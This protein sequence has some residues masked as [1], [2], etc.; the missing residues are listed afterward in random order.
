VVAVPVLAAMLPL[1][2]AAPPASALP[3]FPPGETTTPQVDGSVPA[4]DVTLIGASPEEAGAP[5]ANE[6][7]GVGKLDE[8]PV[9]VRYYQSGAGGGQWTLGPALP[10]GFTP[11]EGPLAATITAK[12]FGAIVGRAKGVV[13]VRKP[14][15]SF[16]ATTQIPVETEAE[17]KSRAEGESAPKEGSPSE[18]E[19]STAGQS[20]TQGQS[21]A[22]KEPAAGGDPA[23]EGGEGGEGGK[24]PEASAA[25]LKVGEELW[26]TG[27]APLV[28]ALEE[29][30]GE[31]GAL[32]AP[33]IGAE[34]GV[35]KQVLH[36]DAHEWASEPID[37]PERSA[38]EF[39]VLA[40]AASSPTNAW[41]LAQPAKSAYPGGAV[42]LFR[43]IEEAGKWS[44][45]PVNLSGGS[46]DGEVHPLLVPVQ[47]GEP[48]PLTVPGTGEPPT[49]KAQLL[50]VTSEGVWIDGRRTDVKETEAG[51]T[52]LYFRPSGARAAGTVVASWCQPPP[53]GRPAC[54]HSLPE[55]LPSALPTGYSRSFAWSGGGPF[56]ERVIT[57]GRE[58][59]SLRLEGESFARVQALGAGK[60][61]EE[62]PGSQLGAAF[63]TP[64]EGW[65]GQALLPVHLT[66]QPVA[67]RLTPW[68]VTVRT[69]LLAVAPE[70][71]A[72]VGSI[73]SEALAVGYE[74]AV[75]RYK[76][77]QGWLPETLFGP[78]EHKETPQLRAIAWPRPTRAYAVGD[79]GQMWL[80]RGET[81]LWE[82]DPA[83]PINFRGNLVGVAFDPNNPARGYAVG[84]TEVGLGGVLLRYGKTWTEET[85]LPPQV[86]GAAF[87]SI[88]FAGS[89]AIVA[90][91]KQAE[92]GKP[93]FAGGL[94]VNDGSGWSVD[95]EAASAFGSNVPLTVA[96]LPDGG[97]AALTDSRALYER[98]GPGSSWQPAPVPP[99]GDGSSLSLFR[100]NGALRAIIA[101]GGVGN[102]ST[103]SR[104]PPGSPPPLYNPI[105]SF[106][107]G[108]E[109]A[110]I[111]RQDASGWSDES[112]ELDPVAEPEGGYR[113]GWDM[114]YR[115]DPIN[116]V[117]VDST[118]SQGW[119][120]GGY[121]EG[122]RG[123]KLLDT[124]D[125]ERYPADGNAP[126]GIEQA[127]VPLASADV[128]VAIGGHAE[129]ANPC[130][131]RS[132]AGVGP[133]VWLTAAVALARK[134]GVPFVYTGPSMSKAEIE[135]RERT[136]PLSFSQEF[137][138]TASILSQGSSPAYVVPTAQDRDARPESAGDES[139]FRAIFS[140]QLGGESGDCAVEVNCSY[141]TLPEASSRGVRTIVLDDGSEVGPEQMAWLEAELASAKSAGQPAIAIGETDL[142][143]RVS[144]GQAWARR[145]TELLVNG[146]SA[147]SGG[148][149]RCGASAYF[150]DAPEEDVHR[151][152]QANGSSIEAYGSGTLGYISALKEERSD[153]HGASGILLSQV[154]VAG[155]NPLTNVAP[156]SVRLIPVIGELGLEPK[157]GILL[158]RSSQAL[159]AG[160]ARRP[161][162]GDAGVAD[163]NESSETDPYIPI[164]EE[165]VGS[166]CAVGLFPEYTLTSSDKEVGAFVKRNTA[167][168]N[169]AIVPLQ[170]AHGE[171]INDEPQPGQPLS[172]AE[173]GLFCAFN[174]GTTI[175]TISAGGLAASL[176]VT[177]QPGSVRQP[178]G[179]TPLKKAAAA[180]EQASVAPPPAPAPAPAG[181]APSSSPSPALVPPA[182]PPPAAVP[183]AR[184]AHPSPPPFLPLP[185]PPAPL[186]AFVP[187]PIPTPARP[188]PP[189]GTS[190]VTS[191][192]EMAEREEEEEEA[193]E[194]VS[195]QAVAYRAHESEPW[196]AYLIGVVV[197]AAFAGAS[198]GRPR[199]RRSEARVAHATVSTTHTQRRLGPRSQRLG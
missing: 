55:P 56:G 32:V 80:W 28:A 62:H 48:E 63:S 79:H 156:V 97:A 68:P 15:G 51:S 111:L 121:Y 52:T 4:H 54:T 165:C 119:A 25:R 171:P 27:R 120:V 124:A 134:I 23:A 118:G 83:T 130:A 31:A 88:A 193:T 190:A 81:G 49:V 75:S 109:T 198:M 194:S 150:Y 99:P 101:G 153:F 74:G 72:P 178:C 103:P 43:R 135:G 144:A 96:G 182:P 196:P 151:P 167:A 45:E 145:V 161:R 110:V 37:V 65:L 170:N 71:G 117:L 33:V 8:R 133:Q 174:A 60:S 179:T 18:G 93:A 126:D 199:R 188:T 91:R 168:A 98:E 94:L 176:P 57:G 160:L 82:R 44:W 114:P 59:V 185:A 66:E 140:Q 180:Q 100:E 186:L 155:R 84:T 164:P 90:Y 19:S 39:R 183:P 6:V 26:S 125:I 21:S 123:R 158:R 175:V 42:A 29:S 9:L 189:T 16:E 38:S 148:G 102:L 13:L 14:G 173:S 85:A 107:V 152:L 131:N 127:D 87:T 141:Y 76:P 50:T 129:C 106:G 61:A 154:E 40:I 36:W 143:A 53:E 132:R 104:E 113:G 10:T 139:L 22:G 195:N 95:E 24:Q 69:P 20:S 5:G 184:T 181:A 187:P 92:P 116:A 166:A 41:L 137:E 105:G 136:A 30:D 159:F 12:G 115:P 64:T 58:G 46:G 192:V 197:L 35:E 34:A 89:E 163:S 191:P 142:N 47:E 122:E 169:G 112:H 147:C 157:S 2:G 162:A 67:S 77:G 3:P 17:A 146:P 73:S 128:T 177:V 138:R 70:P 172:E 11:L 7:W 86:Q 1:P 149:A 108:P 78:G